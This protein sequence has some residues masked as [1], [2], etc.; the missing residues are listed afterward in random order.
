MRRTAIAMAALVVAAAPGA[1]AHGLAPPATI[2]TVQGQVGDVA[3]DSGTVAWLESGASGCALHVHPLSGGTDRTAKYSP[4][5]LPG[6]QDLSLAGGRAAWGGYV[7]VRCSETTAAVYLNA[8]LV[9]EFPGDCLGYRTAFQGLA[10]DGTSFFAALLETSPPPGSSR[11][12]DGGPCHWQLAGGRIVRL[13][14]SK[15]VTVPGLPPAA[16]IAGSNG[17]LALVAPAQTASSNGR[18]F[19]WPRAATNGTVQIRDAKSARLL[20][21][22]RPQGIVRAIALSAT[23]AVVLVQAS[24]ALRVEWYDADSGNRLGSTRVPG[25]T[26]RH[27]STDGRFTAFA[28]GKTVRVLDIETGVQRIVS[29]ATS[30][31]VGLSVRA[32]RLVWGE[33]GAHTGRI[34]SATA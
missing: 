4:G 20:T 14:G 22:F 34:V 9:Q 3:Q 32:G 19:D 18:T 6:E 24:A 5:C 10:T 8:K 15:L 25:S 28:A 21:S 27:L 33:N 11:C 31:P 17:R 1:A 7:E 13:A 12:G 30:E 23:R 26:A 16:L 29:T 2:A